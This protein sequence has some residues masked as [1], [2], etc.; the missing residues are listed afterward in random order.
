MYST[1]EYTTNKTL[2]H[3]TVR[4]LRRDTRLGVLSY[5]STIVTN[6]NTSVY[7]YIYMYSV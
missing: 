4:G 2:S 6:S 7:I 3:S 1:K 5:D